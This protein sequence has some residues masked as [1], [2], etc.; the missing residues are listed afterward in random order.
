MVLMP[1]N[2][3]R[4]PSDKHKE[5]H[6]SE[7]ED[8]FVSSDLLEARVR[9]I[10]ESGGP[11]ALLLGAIADGTFLMRSGADI[12]GGL[13]AL[14]AHKDSHVDGADPFE[15]TDILEAIVK[16]LLE[17]GGPT[18]LLI[19]AIADGQFLKR[20]G[21]GIVGSAAGGD[22][23]LTEIGQAKLLA[24]ASHLVIPLGANTLGR[25]GVFWG[26]KL[27]IELDAEVTITYPC[28][29][30]GGD[31]AA[32]NY[33]SH[34]GASNSDSRLKSGTITV[35]QPMQFILDLWEGERNNF[36][37]WNGPYLS[38]LAAVAPKVICGM[39]YNPDPVHVISEIRI[40]CT[41]S[42]TYG[43]GTKVTVYGFRRIAFT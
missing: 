4:V 2:V 18:A 43:T 39:W 16:R 26:A 27:L 3:L 25:G 30:L 7:K 20:D 9:R 19:G 40:D 34:T 38:H 37:F 10:L 33:K 24:P 13:P 6:T 15:S 1:G 12:V 17:S 42:G 14:P 22:P 31:T 29:Y 23:G 21:T 36:Y 28:L 41:T 5:S 32:A 8:A 11:T 35:S